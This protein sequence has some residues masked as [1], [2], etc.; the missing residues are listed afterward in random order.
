VIVT[1][2]TRSYDARWREGES[3]RADSGERTIGTGRLRERKLESTP[4]RS[5]R[6]RACGCGQSAVR[7]RASRCRAELGTASGPA[8]IRVDGAEGGWARRPWPTARRVCV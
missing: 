5:S 1:S 6:K 3:D 2:P 7:M 4:E 8:R